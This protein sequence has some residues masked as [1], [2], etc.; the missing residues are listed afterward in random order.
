[1]DLRIL[2]NEL[3]RDSIGVILDWVPSHFCKDDMDYICLMGLQPMNMRK[4]GGRKIRGW[5]TCNFDLGR[6]EVKS[7]S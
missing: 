3:H 1:M 6:P 4:I 5:G 2:I 7:P